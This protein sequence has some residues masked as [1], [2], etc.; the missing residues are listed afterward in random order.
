MR[1]RF[2]FAV[3]ALGAAAGALAACAST[4]GSAVRAPEPLKPVDAAR[5]YDGVWREIGRR[6]MK[7]TDGCVAG[8]TTY[9]RTS[10]TDVQVLDTCQSHTPTGKTKSIG[11]PARIQDPGRNTKLHV[12][13]K[14]FGFIEVGK[15]Y[16][17]LDHDD[18]YRW[19]ISADPQFKNLWIY[20]RDPRVSPEQKTALI[21]RARTLGYD[22]SKLEFPAQP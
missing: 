12:D 16:W 21:E 14:L 19:F 15:D 9:H 11:G 20:T 4:S 18:D 2:V 3:L 1:R 22:V 7:L 6:P 5:L 13:Y 10:D 8:A 17:I